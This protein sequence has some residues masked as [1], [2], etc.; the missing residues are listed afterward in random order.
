MR[1]ERPAAI[2]ALLTG[3]N[4][5][6]YVDRYLVAAVSPKFQEELALSQFQTGLVISAFMVGYFVTSPIFGA[7]GD[8]PGGARRHLMA[9]GVAL[10]SVATVLSGMAHGITS[11][12]LARV[13]VGVGEASYATIAPTII[14][15]LAPAG[16][17][18]RWLAI[19]YL[20]TPVGSALG[21]LLG[22][23]L[24]HAYGWRSAF[25]V[26]GG[27]GVALA[28]LVLLVR[29]PVR[30]APIEHADKGGL[31]VLLRSPMYVACVAGYCAYTFAVGGFAAWA[32]KFLYQ[33][34]RLPLVK[35]DF[36]FG[37]VAVLAGII[38]TVLGGTVADR[39]LKG[40]TEDQRIRAYLRYSAIVTAIGV[41]LAAATV[42]AGSPLLFFVAIFLCETALFA[43][44]SPINAVILGSVPP[45]VR[46]TAMAASI[47]AIHALGDFI[48][49][50]L[51]GWVADR[52]T[53]RA[54]LWLLPVAVA[55]CAVI[56]WR[57]SRAVINRAPDQA[58][59]LH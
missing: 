52:A 43:S 51:I 34:H 10:W 9:L 5:L 46:A 28:L 13:A 44:T 14:D 27:P 56:W 33:V 47:F 20:A 17:K 36:F 24:E 22:G 18:N 25:F 19:F 8:R 41:P 48:S 32:P 11:M 6:N 58:P 1:I 54:G 4:F 39:G 12:V 21:Y 55:V 59:A 3:L 2:L 29:D 15:D 35:A 57:G 30:I 38:G 45:A 50:P 42:V 26:A 31:R 49:P 53:L 7:L 16:R 37:V 23:F 40:A